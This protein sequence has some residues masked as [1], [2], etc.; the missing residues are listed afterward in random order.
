M[1]YSS[2]Y[3][4]SAADT[5]TGAQLGAFA[6]IMIILSLIC[7]AISVFYI[8]ALWKLFKKAGKNGWEAIIPIYS[9]YVL[10]EI[11]GYPGWYA[12]LSFIPYAGVAINLVFSII[13]F[14]SLAKK[15]GKSEGFGVLT[16]FF[17]PI[18]IPILAFGSSTY[19]PALGENKINNQ[20]SNNQPN[21]DNNS[22]DSQFCFNCGKKLSKDANVC[23]E[24]GTNL[25]DNQ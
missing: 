15:F 17:S 22:D 23:S 2:S 14:M 8:V 19:N 10:F 11:S 13:A 9:Q 3:S 12:F 16:A 7:I 5:L 4:T 20:Q 21:N 25:K 24:C 6:A 18:C 1:N